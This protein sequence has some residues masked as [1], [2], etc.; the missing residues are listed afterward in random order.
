MVV[1][2]E[3]EGRVQEQ[4]EIGAVVETVAGLVVAGLVVAGLVV[5]AEQEREVAPGQVLEVEGELEVAVSLVEVVGR[6]FAVA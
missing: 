6:A 4:L 5:V 3:L 1:A 2:G